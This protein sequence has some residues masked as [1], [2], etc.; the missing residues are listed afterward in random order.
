MAPHQVVASFDRTGLVATL[1]ERA[2]PAVS[3]VD[4]AHVTPAERLHQSADRACG[5][6]RDEQVDMV[7]HQHIYRFL[8]G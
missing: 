5:G 8:A 3:V 2:R 4:V 1:P 6:R 7:G